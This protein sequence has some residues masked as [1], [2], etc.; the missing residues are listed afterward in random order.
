MTPKKHKLPSHGSWSAAIA[1]AAVVSRFA[2][3]NRVRAC[4]AVL[5]VIA[6][7]PAWA[8]DTS[9]PS[10]PSNLSATAVSGSQVNVSWRASTDNVGVTG[11]QV[12]RCQGRN[13][14]NYAQ[15][16]ITPTP[17]FT[18][19][20]LNASTTYRYRVRATDAAGNLS[21]N[22]SSVSAT[23]LSSV[24]DLRLTKTHV[25]SFTRGQ[26]GATYTLTVRNSGSGPSSGT[27]TVTDTLPAGLAATAIAGSGWAC[28]QPAGPCTRADALAAGA[29]FAPIT[30]TVNVAANAPG[31]VTNTA[32][33]SGGADG[34]T[35]NNSA[36]DPTTIV[37]S[38][39]LQLTKSHA[40]VFTPGQTGATYTLTVRNSGTAASIGTVTVT[41]TVPAGLTATAIVGSGWTCTQPAG[42]CSRSDALAARI[43]LP[44]DHTDSER[45]G[46]RP[47]RA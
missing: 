36:S 8:A 27:V 3:I 47:R 16:G 35:N 18:N 22:S 1:L 43:Q 31:S 32:S 14:S 2:R 19:S 34:S 12:Y 42:P 11:Y 24:P 21:N 4:F 30:L 38:A 26:T 29:S 28:S 45:C 5:S 6:L 44:A 10:T 33:V 40:G 41:D 7:L 20:G 23:T 15:I 17:G 37:G 46:R 9:R 25:G 13:C 39:D